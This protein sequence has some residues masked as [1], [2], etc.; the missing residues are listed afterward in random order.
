[1]QGLSERGCGGGEAWKRGGAP[2]TVVTLDEGAASAGAA[3]GD[4]WGAINNLVNLSNI[5][6]N[7]AP[8][9]QSSSGS[10]TTDSRT[11]NSFAGLD[12]FSKN[13]QSMV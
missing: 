8:K 11:Q 9:Q 2:G 4:K 7:D 13:Q 3:S 10:I 6:T 5:S 12:G 1:M